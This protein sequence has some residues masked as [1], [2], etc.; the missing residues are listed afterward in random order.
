MNKRPLILAA[1]LALLLSLT[2]LAAF[3]AAQAPKPA[4]APQPRVTFTVSAVKQP[5]VRKSAETITAAQLEDYLSFVASDEMEGRADPSKGLDI[6]AKFIA[7]LLDRWGVRP[8]GDGR[9]FFQRITLRK[10]KLAEGT[11]VDLNGRKFVAGKDF[12]ARPLAG[13]ASGSMVFAG[14]GLFLKAKNIDAYQGLDPKGKIVVLTQ[15]GIPA[16]VTI[17]DLMGGKRGEDWVDPIAYAEKKG[18]VGVVMLN[19][20]LVQASPESMENARKSAETSSFY[21]EKLPKPSGG[22]LPAIL[23]NLA[24]VNAIFAGEKTDA[25]TVLMN[26]PG[27]TPVKSFELTP[28]KKLTLTIKTSSETVPSQNVVAVVEGSDP[29]LKAEYVALGAHYDHIG[30]GAPINGDTIRNGAD[31]DGSGTVALLAMAEALTKAGRHP[32]RSVLFVWHMGEEMGLWGSQYYATYPTV[33]LDKVVAQLNIDMIGRSRQPGDTNPRNKDLSGPNELYVIGSKMMSTELGALSEAVNGAYLKMSLNYKYDDPK[34]PE[35]FFYRSDHINYA[36]KDVPIIFYFTGVHA[37]YH[38]PSDEVSKIDFQKYEKVT[39]T[40]YMTLWE[41]GEMKTR[42]KV[43]HPLP[44]A[45][46]NGGF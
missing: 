39:R 14:D 26:L 42:P 38:Q 20:L 23:A 3:Q 45:V 19:S 36:R 33:P 40:I 17:A 16:G 2:P 8:A 1:V 15:G 10:E 32:K 27:G 6:T 34:D 9:T 22:Q 35:Q 24:L 4:P 30:V 18:A 41:I 13:S 11:D 37:D 28:D 21:P 7:T 5:F 44:D 31:D 43:D 29:V 46:K 25:R 12:F